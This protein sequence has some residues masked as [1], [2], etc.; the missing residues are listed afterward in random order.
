[1]F[2][3]LSVMRPSS[4]NIREQGMEEGR[5]RGICR[6]QEEAKETWRERG[7]LH[8]EGDVERYEV[9]KEGEEE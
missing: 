8:G 1:M 5:R 2:L 3:V 9:V 6:G 7:G 4:G